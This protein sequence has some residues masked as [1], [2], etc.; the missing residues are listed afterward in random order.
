MGWLVNRTGY[1]RHLNREDVQVLRYGEV[2][3]GPLGERRPGHSPA[4]T[5][6]ALVTPL[7]AE[8][9]LKLG[10]TTAVERWRVRL[11]AGATVT[12]QDRLQVRGQPWRVVSVVQWR[13]YVVAVVE[14]V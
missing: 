7:G 1:L 3:V 2:Q 5:Y 8:A 12:T 11:P 6:S 9:A 4:E 10:L 14:G 13:S